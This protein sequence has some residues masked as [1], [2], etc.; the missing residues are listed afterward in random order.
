MRDVYLG[1]GSNIGDRQKNLKTALKLISEEIGQIRKISSVYE[2]EPWGLTSQ[3]FFLNQVLVVRTEIKP[4]DLLEK[5]SRI[6]K[7]AGRKRKVKW[8]PRILDIDILLYDDLILKTENLIIPHPQITR[9]AFVLIPLLE[10]KPDL[11]DPLSGIQYKSYLRQ[12]GEVRGITRLKPE[13][14]L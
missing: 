2:T 3:P 6:E 1:I 5:I 10:I 7:N 11:S 8:G 4:D 12:I 13:L 14:A 9:R